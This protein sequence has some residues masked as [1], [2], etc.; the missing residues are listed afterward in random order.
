MVQVMPIL[1]HFAGYWFVN[2]LMPNWAE[3]AGNLYLAYWYGC[4][5]LI[6]LIALVFC[7]SRVAKTLLAMSCSWSLAIVLEMY[8]VQDQIQQHDWIAQYALDASLIIAFTYLGAGRI[9][10]HF[11]KQQGTGIQV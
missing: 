2:L 10:Q 11:K 8:F 4:F 1:I 3:E 7:E 9:R 5:A 6:D